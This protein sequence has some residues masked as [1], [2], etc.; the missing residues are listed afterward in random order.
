MVDSFLSTGR[1]L[2][3]TL[4]LLSADVLGEIICGKLTVDGVEG[5][6]VYG[7]LELDLSRS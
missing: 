4:L 7:S 6:G 1:S 5:H 3:D 2:C